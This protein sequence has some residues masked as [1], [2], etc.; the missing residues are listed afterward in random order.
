MNLAP[1][2]HQ[3]LV[4][5]HTHKFM[6]LFLGKWAIVTAPEVYTS[7]NTRIW[8]YCVCKHLDVFADPNNYHIP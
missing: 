2:G 6:Y 1:R 8:Y 4:Q 7:S 3:H 5:S